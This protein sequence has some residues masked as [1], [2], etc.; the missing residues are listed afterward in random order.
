[1]T[2]HVE[3]RTAVRFSKI[4]QIAL[5]MARDTIEAVRRMGR[6]GCARSDLGET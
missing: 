6:Q 3:G 2:A 4:R 5:V 1:M